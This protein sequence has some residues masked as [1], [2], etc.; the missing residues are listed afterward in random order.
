[1]KNEEEVTGPAID[2]Y[3][4]KI[5]DGCKYL[6]R[7]FLEWVTAAVKIYLQI[8]EENCIFLSWRRGLPIISFYVSMKKMENIL[9]QILVFCEI[10]TNIE[11]FGMSTL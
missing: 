10:V 6:R 8:N 3:G 7:K 5:A 9:L 2:D 1:M 4:I 11:F